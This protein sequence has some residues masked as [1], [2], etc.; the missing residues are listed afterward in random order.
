M[1]GHEDTTS[2][3]SHLTRATERRG[4]TSAEDAKIQGVPEPELSHPIQHYG[5]TWTLDYAVTSFKLARWKVRVSSL[6][7][8][9]LKVLKD[10]Q[11]LHSSKN[12]T[13]SPRSWFR[14]ISFDYR[15]PLAF[16]SITGGLDHVNPVN[17]VIRLPIE[18]GI[19]S[20]LG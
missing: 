3:T 11:G 4:K 2:P 12:S 6:R 19:S 10:D 9:P 7:R 1:K 15:V 17:P 18:H 16:G 5:V 8:K 20:V 13:R 14:W